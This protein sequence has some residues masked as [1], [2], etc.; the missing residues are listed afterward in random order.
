MFRPASLLPDYFPAA[1]RSASFIL[2]C[3]PGP[4]AWKCSR[5]SRSI[6]KDTTS[7]V[8]GREGRFGA[9]TSG[10]FVVAAL[11]AASATSTAFLGRRVLS[12]G[13]FLLQTIGSKKH[14]RRVARV[15]G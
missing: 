5:T 7:F 11:K 1:F 15:Q 9:M 3:H 8:F 12:K 10:G 13:M 14:F 2:S 4:S 6:R